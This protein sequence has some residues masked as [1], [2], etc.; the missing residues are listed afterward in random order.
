MTNRQETAPPNLLTRVRVQGFRTLRDAGFR[1]GPVSAL[2]GEPGTGKS[3]LLAAVRAILD[4]AN[5]PLV[6]EDVAGDSTTDP[7][8]SRVILQAAR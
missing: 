8:H 1:P 5:A 2:V 7:A 6:A 4:P 3:N